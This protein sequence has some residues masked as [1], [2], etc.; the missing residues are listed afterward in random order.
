M[1]LYSACWKYNQVI[2]EGAPLA[3]VF[4][5]WIRLNG[6]HHVHVGCFD[7]LDLFVVVKM[8]VSPE[9]VWQLISSTPRVQEDSA[10]MLFQETKKMIRSEVKH[11]PYECVNS[12]SHNRI[13]A[14]FWHLLNN[15]HVDLYS[16]ARDGVS[17]Y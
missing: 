12:C 14:S 1:P 15:Q 10:K 13:E 11:G 5:E 17:Q 2:R 7:L 3:G 9:G 8:E 4:E 6:V 16:P